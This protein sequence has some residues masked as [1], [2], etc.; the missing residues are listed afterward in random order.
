M[1][2]SF[3]AISFY[4]VAVGHFCDD[5]AF[6]FGLYGI[7]Q[8]N[9]NV[10]MLCEARI[11]A[12]CRIFGAEISQ[13]RGFVEAELLNREGLFHHTRI[14]VVHTVYIRPYL[15]FRSLD[16]GADQGAE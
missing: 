15:H 11:E 5:G 6:G 7:E 12:G 9:G 1:M 10:K 8:F 3:A 2:P 16:G 14:V 4:A 13:L